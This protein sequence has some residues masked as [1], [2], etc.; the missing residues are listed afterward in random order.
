MREILIVILLLSN[1]TIANKNPLNEAVLRAAR[2]PGLTD[3]GRAWMIKA[4]HP[5][6]AV[7]GMAGIPTLDSR[8]TVPLNFMTTRV[9]TAPSAASWGADVLLNPSPLYFGKVTTHSATPAY[10]TSTIYNTQLGVTG[11]SEFGVPGQTWNNVAVE[12]WFGNVSKYRLCYAS[13]TATLSASSTSNEGSVTCAQYPLVG[14]ETWTSGINLLLP[15][16]EG[17]SKQKIFPIGLRNPQVL[18]GMIGSTTWEAREGAYAILKLSEDALV[19]NKPD[20]LIMPFGSAGTAPNYIQA[21]SVD[22]YIDMTTATAAS[23]NDSPFGPQAIWGKFNVVQSGPTFSAL[24]TGVATLVPTQDYQAHLSFAGL[25][26]AASITLTYR[27]GFEAVVPPESIYAGQVTP[28]LQ[29]DPLALQTYF[30]HSAFLQSAYPASYNIFGALF[31]GLKAVG[32]AVMPHL[33]NAGRTMLSSMSNQYA[34]PNATTGANTVT[35]QYDM[36]PPPQV[37]YM[38]EPRPRTRVIRAPRK[39]S[40]VKF[41]RSAGR[42]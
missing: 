40:K 3:E 34:A 17:T 21:P 15:W 8:P 4:L 7:S 23:V 36:R 35:S 33:V 16:L 25:D 39:K 31:Q 12:T 30:S 32:G 28:A 29:P 13:V 37:Q 5:S 26:P 14:R 41:P 42:R 1:D 10:G 9:I 24:P 27:V 6:D 11:F 19:W 2:T 20:D 22:T 18:Q 38:E